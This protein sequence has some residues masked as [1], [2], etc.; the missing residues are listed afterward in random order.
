[1]E[2]DRRRLL[3]VVGVGWALAGCAAQQTAKPPPDHPTG[4]RWADAE[5]RALP[6]PALKG[7]LPLVEA[8]VAR[9]SVREY[10]P[11]DL[12]AAEIGQLLWAAQG[13][14][15]TDRRTAPSA[16]ALYP[17]EVLVLVGTDVMRYRPD[18]HSV[19]VLGMPS[20]R[21]ALVDAVGQD[22]VRNAPA[23]FV[24]TGVV[25]RLA[26]RYGDRSER[27][28]RL[29]AGHCAQNLLLQATALGLG[30]VPIG[31]FTDSAVREALD[32][33]SGEAPL[34]VIPVGAPSA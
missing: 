23:A 30:A 18:A 6:S 33:Y 3:G 27:Y 11:R 19:A 28:T 32:L 1:M 25:S 24:V 22:P 10:A 20:A 31:A 26:E 13:T 14:R 2:L 5:L 17:L 7:G 21:S 12:T 9:A 34:Y 16:G 29:E 4:T 15:V 8:L